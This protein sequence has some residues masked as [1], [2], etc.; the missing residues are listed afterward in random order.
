MTQMV[1]SMCARTPSHTYTLPHR[2][3]ASLSSANAAGR[4]GWAGFSDYLGR[5]NTYYLFGAG[6]PIAASIPILTSAFSEE[7]S[8]LPLYLFYGGTMVM[9]SFYG[10]I[11]STLPAYSESRSTNLHVYSA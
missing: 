11:F 3:V 1:Y 2:Y 10:G 7:P 4:L 5:K 6:I 8:T 9:I